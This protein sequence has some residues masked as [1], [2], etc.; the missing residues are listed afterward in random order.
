M[1]LTVEDL[2]CQ[3]CT[4]AAYKKYTYEIMPPILAALVMFSHAPVE[5]QIQLTIKLNIIHYNL[6]GVVYHGD[7]HY[8]ARFMDTDGH[9]WYND[10]LTLGRRAQLEG[11]IHDVDMM[12]DR[13]SKSHDILVY[14]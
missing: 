10:G 1:L 11:F 5:E 14:R 6:V 3:R 8:T 9:V 2:A 13:A 4:S 12:K 7:T